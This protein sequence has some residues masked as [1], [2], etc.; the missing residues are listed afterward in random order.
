MCR[1]AKQKSNKAYLSNLYPP[2]KDY[3]RETYKIQN[4]NPISPTAQFLFDIIQITVKGLSTSF[5]CLVQYK[6]N[7]NILFVKL[8]YLTYQPDPEVGSV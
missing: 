7:L 3:F 2:A 6:I 4:I 5:Q 1:L 8:Q